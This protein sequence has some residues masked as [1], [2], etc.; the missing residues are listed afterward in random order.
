MREIPGIP[1]QFKDEKLLHKALTHRSV[2]KV[3]N[4]RLEFLGDSILSAVVST[5]LFHLK[6]DNDEGDLSRLR[7]RIVRGAT[8]AK[9][10]KSLNLS[11]Y[12]KLGEGEM[13]SGGYKRDSILADTFEAIIG[14]IYLDGGYRVCEQAVLKMCEAEIA[15]LPEASELKD[16]KTKLQ[17]WLQTRGYPLP[18][19]VLLSEE[20]P[21]HKKH[22][23][24][25][26]SDTLLGF[27]VTGSGGSRRKAEQ[28]AAK[29][30]LL[31]LSENNANRRKSHE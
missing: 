18:E 25:Q 23:V 19:Y 15:A 20:G 12:V 7:A 14:A 24:V 17:E 4:E 27:D 10:A 6:N 16:P 26:T 13:K 28:S 5:R 2:G 30:A 8:L 1:Y 11:E 22:F 3:N 9:L 21:P 31:Q 29:S